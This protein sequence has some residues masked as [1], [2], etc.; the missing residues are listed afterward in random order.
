MLGNTS[1]VAMVLSS[2]KITGQGSPSS[3]LDNF[4][5]SPI[6]LRCE[7]ALG[8]L[9]STPGMCGVRGSIVCKTIV[10]GVD[11]RQVGREKLEETEPGGLVEYDF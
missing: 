6:F 2:K 8:L 9:F 11:F 10:T 1:C 3:R 4:N 5:C 7:R